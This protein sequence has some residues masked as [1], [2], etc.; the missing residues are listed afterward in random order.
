MPPRSH[1]AV[2]LAGGA[3]DGGILIASRRGIGAWPYFT[4]HPHV[5]CCE[6]YDTFDWRHR[7]VLV[8]VATLPHEFEIAGLTR[9][10][11][12]LRVTIAARYPGQ[13]DLPDLTRLWE[14]VGVPRSLLGSPLP[15]R[16][17]VVAD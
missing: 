16:V 10:G 3:V 17:V 11:D 7:A 6:W 4:M 13:A 8:V 14:A 9:R 2:T 1:P 15:R 12:T 5:G